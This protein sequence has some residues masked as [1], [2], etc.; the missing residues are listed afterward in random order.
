MT[1]KVHAAAVA[2]AL[3]FSCGNNSSDSLDDAVIVEEGQT[4]SLHSE[5]DQ[6]DDSDSDG[7]QATTLGPVTSG[8][9]PHIGTWVSCLGENVTSGLIFTETKFEIFLN[10]KCSDVLTE[11]SLSRSGTYEIVGHG[12]SEEGLA[13]IQLELKNEVVAGLPVINP[14][15]NT[16]LVIHAEGNTLFTGTIDE[17]IDETNDHLGL[18]MPYKR[19]Q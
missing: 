4:K 14:L 2:C 3:L 16:F 10:N 15:P 12:V 18:G 11:E 1:L 19:V 5:E 8:G 7:E 17:V 13:V 9:S 6:I